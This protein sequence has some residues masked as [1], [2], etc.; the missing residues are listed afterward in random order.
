MYVELQVGDGSVWKRESE[1]RENVA[2]EASWPS[3]N[4]F[5]HLDRALLASEVLTITVR[6]NEPDKFDKIIGMASVRLSQL[7]NRVGDWVDVSG[8]LHR[9]VGQALHEDKKPD[10]RFVITVKY[11]S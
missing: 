7:E 11:V 5:G 3:M 2:S 10:G 9:N 8:E 4:I 1:V 6:D